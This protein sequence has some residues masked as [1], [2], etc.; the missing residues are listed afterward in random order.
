M[1]DWSC[2]AG[3]SLI[4]KQMKCWP[5]RELCKSF[6]E[7]AAARLPVERTVVPEVCQECPSC[8]NCWTSLN[9]SP[10]SGGQRVTD[11]MQRKVALLIRGD[12]EALQRVQ[13]GSPQA[14]PYGSAVAISSKDGSWEMEG[15]RWVLIATRVPGLGSSGSIHR[16]SSSFQTGMQL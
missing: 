13:C 8:P 7:S 14:W 10:F 9:I 2:S 1:S 4:A 16:L 3:W 5:V 11:K 6:P 12:D 15:G